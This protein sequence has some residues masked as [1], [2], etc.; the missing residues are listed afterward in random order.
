M[1][2]EYK[3]SNTR[4]FKY[5]ESSRNKWKQRSVKHHKDKRGLALKLRDVTMSRDRWRNEC[6]RLRE[7]NRKLLDN[8]KKAIELVGQILKL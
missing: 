5:F 3:T 7:E 2:K 1:C 8:K 6:K 4:L